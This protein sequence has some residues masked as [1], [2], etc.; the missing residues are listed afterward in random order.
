MKR[1]QIAAVAATALILGA[2]ATTP[3]EPR[4]D[5]FIARLSQAEAQRLG[6]TI[7]APVTLDEVIALS[8]A[9]TPPDRII[10]RM[11]DTAS[12]YRLNSVD[13]ANLRAGGVA[14]QVIE[15]MTSLRE[16]ADRVE[17]DRRYNRVRAY[18]YNDPFYYPWSPFYHPFYYGPSWRRR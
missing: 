4:D 3:P 9:G 6:V 1:L 13:V 11:R 17:D 5:T 14:E 12:V 7:P 2:C 16:L 18:P 15:H 8:K 10:E